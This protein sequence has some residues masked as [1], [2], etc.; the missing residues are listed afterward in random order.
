MLIVPIDSTQLR[1]D[2]VDNTD[3]FPIYENSGFIVYQRLD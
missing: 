2:L 1:D 3:L